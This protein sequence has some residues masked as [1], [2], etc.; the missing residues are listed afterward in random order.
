[1]TAETDR[2][3]RG[4]TDYLLALRE[5]SALIE[6]AEDNRGSGPLRRAS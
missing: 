5:L 2:R 6:E 4:V 1:M 3:Q